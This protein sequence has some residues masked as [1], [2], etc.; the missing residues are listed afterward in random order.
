MAVPETYQSWV[1]RLRVWLGDDS[2]QNKLYQVQES[3]DEFFYYAIL[4][5]IEQ[6]NH[7]IGYKTSLTI[8]D[9]GVNLPWYL[10]KLGATLQVLIGKG[11]LSARNIL[12]YTDAGGVQVS[13]MDTYGRYVNYFNV[14]ITS[15]R[16][17]LIDFKVRLNLAQGWGE[18][19]SELRNSS[20]SDD[21]W[22]TEGSM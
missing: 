19:G 21:L 18:F 14:L 17:D 8:S 15:Y 1:D 2:D 10:V 6:I 13:D 12:S 22:W 5:A 4:D 3:S 20:T 16:Q 7:S 11:I 9:L